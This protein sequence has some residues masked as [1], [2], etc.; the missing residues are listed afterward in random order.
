[1][2]TINR[3]QL[4]D[5][6]DARLDRAELREL[7]YDVGLD[8]DN[9]EG[10]TK[11][12]DLLSLLMYHDQRQT[13]DQLVAII[14]QRRPDLGLANTTVE[15]TVAPPPSPVSSA[16]T[17]AP[18]PVSFVSPVSPLPTP[19][20]RGVPTSTPQTAS[21]LATWTTNPRLRP[22]GYVA[23]VVLGALALLLL[24]TSVSSD[25]TFDAMTRVM[26]LVMAAIPGWLALKLWQ[27]LRS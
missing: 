16:A 11:R 5:L 12:E 3:Q 14:A 17:T 8:L 25:P 1:M 13:L 9:L 4:L 7:A 18:T 15:P 21:L 2:P 20:S 10:N 22:L 24:A 6:L 19:S 23:I 27:M 26:A